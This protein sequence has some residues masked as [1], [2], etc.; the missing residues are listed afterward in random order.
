MLKFN[1]SLQKNKKQRAKMKEAGHQAA[2]VLE[3]IGEYV[4]DGVTTEELD[5]ICH[6]F[7]VNELKSI[8]ACLGY[9][10]FPKSIC[11]SVNDVVCHGI[12]SSSEVLSNG[13][14]INIDVTVIADGFHG[15]TSR[16]YSVGEVS[17]DASNIS[18]AS[19]HAM[20]AGINAIK[21]GKDIGVVGTAIENYLK[22]T[23]YSICKEYCGHGIGEE[24]HEYPCVLSYAHE[25]GIILAPGMTFTVEPIINLGSR[26]SIKKEGCDWVVYTK[27]GTLSAQHE[28]TIL[29][30][31]RGFE[32][33]TLRDE[34]RNNAY[35]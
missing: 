24:F 22:D 29:V 12:P 2:L 31:K 34:E 32:I 20:M 4:V 14:I 27:D 10:G 16:M 17:D 33:L 8:P 21:P 19:Y 28:H 30:T 7:I 5:Q 11:T 25:Y 26:D 13:D 6:D 23:P 1:K 3:M 15:D 18:K 9:K 35:P